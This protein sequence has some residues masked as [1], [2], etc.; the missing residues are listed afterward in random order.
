MKAKDSEYGQCKAKTADGEQCK[1]VA[2]KNGYCKIGI[3]QAQ[4]EEE[5]VVVVAKSGTAHVEER[6]NRLEIVPD[7]E[8]AEVKEEVEPVPVSEEIPLDL[9]REVHISSYA[10]ILLWIKRTRPKVFKEIDKD[11]EEEVLNYAKEHIEELPSPSRVI[12]K[13][14][15][16]QTPY[17]LRRIFTEIGIVQLDLVERVRKNEELTWKLNNLASPVIIVP[18]ILLNDDGSLNRDALVGMNRLVKQK[19]V[20][21][22]GFVPRSL[23]GGNHALN[24]ELDEIIVDAIEGK[25]E[26]S[27]K[28]RVFNA[29][30]EEVR[31]KEKENQRKSQDEG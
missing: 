17:Q 16:Q 18:D 20:R 2:S 23:E 11:S 10:A 27:I 5:G 24:H 4:V 3:H 21:A 14:G 26:D 12:K 1:M 25:L 13:L 9:E 15:Q 31:E 6:V 7:V 22:M 8:V 30:T 29:S 28:L 19:M